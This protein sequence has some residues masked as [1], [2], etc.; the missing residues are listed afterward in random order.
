[1]AIDNAK[2]NVFCCT[3]FE[4][5]SNQQSVC[6]SYL[7]STATNN[8]C[9]FLRCIAFC[10]SLLHSRFSPIGNKT[11]WLNIEYTM[12]MSRRASNFSVVESNNGERGL[13]ATGRVFVHRRL[14]TNPRGPER[15]SN[16]GEANL[17]RHKHW[18]QRHKHWPQRHKHCQ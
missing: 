11:K 1:M 3:L 17:Q 6:F 15:T 16:G 14:P 13:R 10:A 9:A 7:N 8:P 18:L 2:A 4:L 12:M 5:Y